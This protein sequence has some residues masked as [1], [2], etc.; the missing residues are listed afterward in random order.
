MMEVTIVKIFL[1]ISAITVYSFTSYAYFG[2]MITIRWLNINFE[3]EIL[4]L[5]GIGESRMA[6]NEILMLDWIDFG[7]S[8]H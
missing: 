3:V 4:L 1:W 6:F 5:K 2:R 7:K 8:L